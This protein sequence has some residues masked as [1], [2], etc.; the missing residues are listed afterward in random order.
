MKKVAGCGFLLPLASV[1]LALAA[2]GMLIA[3]WGLDP[4]DA[5]RSLLAGAFG[6]LN[7][8]G[9]SLV[10]TV[11]LIFT[12]LAYATAARS[13]LVNIGAEGQLYMGGFLAALAGGY[14]T[15]LP[16]V[17]HLPLAVLAGFT[18]GGLWGLLAGWLKVK[19]GA[20][21]VITTIMLNYIAQY[22]VGFLV[23]GPM[24]APPGTFPQ[25]LPVGHTAI[26]PR[27]LPG[28][29]LHLGIILA[30]FCVYGFYFF[31][32]RTVKGYETRVAGINPE[33]ALYAGMDPSK[34]MLLG[35]FLAGGFAGLAGASE[36]LGVQLRLIANFSPGYGFDGIAVALLGRNSPAGVILAALLFGVFR[37]G[38]NSMQRVS[39]VPV[40]V[41]NII[42]ALVI[43][44]LI[45]GRVV[46]VL[47]RKRAVRK[48]AAEDSLR[49]SREGA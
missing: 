8:L 44:F 24:K 39:G 40:S 20:G 1:L 36:I 3:L 47:L 23:G 15:G 14:I 12:G 31:L 48:A 41:V 30:L 5:G 21:E 38:A 29:R 22:W 37:A 33:A 43:L 17:I 32:W 42:Q 2:G 49:D 4:F 46:T 18:G 28:T 13:G 10:K 25:S 19:F 34:T 7:A 11:P 16:P 45:S 6:N 9:E 26:L 27:I 35:M